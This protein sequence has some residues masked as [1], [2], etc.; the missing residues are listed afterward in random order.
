[1]HLRMNDCFRGPH[2]P[3]FGYEDCG[4]R[5][6]S[7]ASDDCFL[8]KMSSGN[9]DHPLY[10]PPKNPIKPSQARRPEHFAWHHEAVIFSWMR[11]ENAPGLALRRLGGSKWSGILPADAAHEPRPD[12][13]ATSRWVQILTRLYLLTCDQPLLS[14]VLYQRFVAIP[15]TKI[16]WSRSSGNFYLCG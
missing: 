16:L 3:R 13:R 8:D 5:R 14:A 11:R 2:R 9:F 7:G 15:P 10:F 4:K 12:H 6:Q 1:M